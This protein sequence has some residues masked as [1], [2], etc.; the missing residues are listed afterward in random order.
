[1]TPD[2][3]RA[4]LGVLNAECETGG[5]TMVA[6]LLRWDSATQT[7]AGRS[8]EHRGFSGPSHDVRAIRD[9]PRRAKAERLVEPRRARIDRPE[10]EPVE[11]AAGPC[12]RLEHEAAPDPVSA[13]LGQ[14]V[15]V[16]HAPDAIIVQVGIDA[17]AAH[18]D[19][20]SLHLGSQKGL[21]RPGKAVGVA[22]PLVGDPTQES[23]SRGLA[24]RQ[25][26]CEILGGS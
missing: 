5:Q 9:A 14:D 26:M 15:H 23:V 2:E 22:L 10:P 13:I 20:H 21:A 19:E 25:Q 24:L 12:D 6:R 4:S 11:A 1:M 18:A 17:Q 3:I 8:R 16:P 7:C